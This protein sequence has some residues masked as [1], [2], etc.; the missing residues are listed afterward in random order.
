[1]KITAY[2]GSLIHSVRFG[3][4]QVIDSG[5]IGVNENGI[6]TFVK[7]LHEETLDATEYDEVHL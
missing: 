2:K 1:M 6:I 3:E 7:D 4:L 5:V